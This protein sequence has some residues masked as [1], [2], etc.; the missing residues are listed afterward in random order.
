MRSR[1]AAGGKRAYCA[2]LATFDAELEKIAS[3]RFDPDVMRSILEADTF[4]EALDALDES[5]PAELA[6]D[7]AAETEWYRTRW[8]DVIAEHGH[9]IRHI[10]VDG[11]PE[12]RAVFA[13]IHPD[14]VEHA[15][16]TTA[17]EEQV[18]AS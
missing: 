9:D 6:A 13:E 11:T 4:T 8:S 12:D 3:S 10:W 18:Y 16:R 5:A 17:Y 7:V 1:S 2:A 14:I 15:A